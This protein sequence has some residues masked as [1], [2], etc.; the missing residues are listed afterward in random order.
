M[1]F[2]LTTLFYL[3][4]LL[5]SALAAF[6]V[7]GLIPFAAIPGMAWY[8]LR[9]RHAEGAMVLPWFVLGMAAFLTILFQIEKSLSSRAGPLDLERVAS[10][11]TF[12]A[13]ALVPAF[14]WGWRLI[15]PRSTTPRSESHDEVRD[16]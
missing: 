11:G 10:M 5:A 1:T 6:G 8:A 15:V 2:R 13:L 14:P 9:L 3:T 4:A 12:F 16:A 7:W